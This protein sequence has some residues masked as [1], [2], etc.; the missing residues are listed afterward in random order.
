MLALAQR[1][2]V[3]VGKVA[4]NMMEPVSVVTDFVNTGC[5]LLGS[6]FVFA[7][8]VK[9]FEHRRS[10]LMVTMTTVVFLF[11]AGLVLLS[12]PLIAYLN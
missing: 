11:I 3:G 1:N 10:P 2:N 5:L 12:L 6:A 8:I 4:T 7:S 9:Y